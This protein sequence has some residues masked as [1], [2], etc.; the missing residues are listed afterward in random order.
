M[1]K[2]LGKGGDDGIGGVNVSLAENIRS[3][4]QGRKEIQKC[5]HVRIQ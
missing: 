4:T 3:S 5:L 1:R 2:K